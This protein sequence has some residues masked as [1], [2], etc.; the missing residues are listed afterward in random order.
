MWH[1]YTRFRVR[2]GRSRGQTA[3][4]L[5]A[6]LLTERWVNRVISIS[7]LFFIFT[8]CAFLSHRALCHIPR[9][10][11]CHLCF[12][13]GGK[14]FPPRNES[15]IRRNTHPLQRYGYMG[16][17]S[18]RQSAWWPYRKTLVRTFGPL[19]WMAVY[20][21]WGQGDIDSALV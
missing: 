7:P 12:Q 19:G 6:S 11:I 13:S 15:I 14:A 18:I 3:V 8:I 5:L 4:S 21:L 20:L 16:A 1:C 9:V 2:G 17:I 10:I